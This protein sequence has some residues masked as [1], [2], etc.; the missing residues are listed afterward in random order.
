MTSTSMPSGSS[1][2]LR[3]AVTAGRPSRAARARQARSPRKKP[4]G[5]A[6]DLEGILFMEG[7]RL[8]PQGLKLGTDAMRIQAFGTEFP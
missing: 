1:A 7:N 5:L 4:F 8:L 3:L 6:D 2:Q